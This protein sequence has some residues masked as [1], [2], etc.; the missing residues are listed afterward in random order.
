M[1]RPTRLLGSA[2]FSTPVRTCGSLTDRLCRN[3]TPWPALPLMPLRTTTSW[4]LML[5][6]NAPNS[7]VAARTAVAIAMPLVMAF[8]VLP[9]ASSSVRICAPSSST[10]PDISAM[11]WALSLTGPKVSIATM[12]PTVVSRPQ[13]ASATANSDDDDR[14]AAEQE[15]TEDGR[16]DDERGVDRRLEA[17]REARQDDGGRAGQRGLADILDR[18]GLGAGEVARERQDQGGEHDA[19]EHRDDRDE[20]AGSSRRAARGGSAEQL[21]R[22]DRSSL[23][24]MSSSPNVVGR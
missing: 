12:T 11:P 24:A 23:P 15:R 13:P 22:P 6:V 4:S 16:A 19:D 7:A 21:A 20:C 1:I 2:T 18:A 9:T 3:S 10:S 8:V 17:D 14:A 5:S